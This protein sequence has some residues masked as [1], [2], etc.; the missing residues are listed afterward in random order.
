MV[1]I[2]TL[3]WHLIEGPRATHDLLRVNALALH[4]VQQWRERT[5]NFTHR[6]VTLTRP[7]LSR[8]AERRVRLCPK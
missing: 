6:W 8:A 5:T 1:T 7:S 2:P 4:E 3:G